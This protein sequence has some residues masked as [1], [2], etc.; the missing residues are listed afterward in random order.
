[1]ERPIRNWLLS[2]SQAYSTFRSLIAQRG[3]AA[4]F[5]QRFVRAGA[6][7]RILD[8]GCG[9]ADLL[10][11]F[12]ESVHYEGFDANP[13]YIDH[14]RRAYRDRDASFQCQLVSQAN[15]TAPGSWDLV[16]AIGLVHHL[17]DAEAV[18]LFR[19][20]HDALRPGGRMVTLDGVYVPEQSRLARWII[21]C[22][23]GRFVRSREEYEA[24]GRIA[25]DTLETTV[26][27]RLLR[28]PYTHLIMELRKTGGA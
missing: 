10:A 9:P 20:G 11:Y 14:A 16:L 19:L 3:G 25:F 26:E 1:M 21:S 15:L 8:I 12:P 28:M 5:V 17:D 24:L 4:R 13:G 6:E 23:R 18:Q 2:H 27:H 7:D 22:D